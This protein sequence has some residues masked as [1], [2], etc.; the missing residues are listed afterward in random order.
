MR[1]QRIYQLKMINGG[2]E[3]EVTHA[4]LIFGIVE[5]LSVYLV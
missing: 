4:K 2:L 5:V 1:T 3:I